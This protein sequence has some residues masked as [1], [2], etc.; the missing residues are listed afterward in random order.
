MAKT[1]PSKT[2]RVVAHALVGVCT[3]VVFSQKAGFPGFIVG[4]IAGVI[5]HAFFDAPLA[6]AIAEIT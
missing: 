2:D 4:A 1:Q 6:V 5:A 3:G